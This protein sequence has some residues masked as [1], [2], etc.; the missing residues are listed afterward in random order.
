MRDSDHDHTDN[1]GHHKYDADN[2]T[3]DITDHQHDADNVAV[4]DGL[5]IA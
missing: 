2:V 4:V 5:N 1:D 3:D